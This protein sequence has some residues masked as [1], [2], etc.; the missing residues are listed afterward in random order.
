M[1]WGNYDTV[2]SG[3]K[4]DS[5][6]ASPAAV[7]YA[8]ANFSSSY[9]SGLTHSLPASLYYTSKP[10]WWPSTKAWP[11]IGPDVVIGQSGTCSGTYAGAQ[12]TRR[13]NVRAAR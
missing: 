12:A 11:A 4:W 3:V 6:E 13:P 10:S 2:T 9:F 5:T 7:A 8:G 1:R